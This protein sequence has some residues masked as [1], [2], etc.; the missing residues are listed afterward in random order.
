MV[1]NLGTEARL[2]APYVQFAAIPITGLD[3]DGKYLVYHFKITTEG[4]VRDVRLVS[5]S[6]EKQVTLTSRLESW[7]FRAALRAGQAM[8][9]EAVLLVP[10]GSVSK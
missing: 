2:V 3:H 1:V 4:K 10:P 9:L 6:V 5:G 8:P 7:R